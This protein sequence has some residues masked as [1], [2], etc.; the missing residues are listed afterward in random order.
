V[1]DK[2]LGVIAQVE[3]ATEDTLDK[4]DSWYH[5]SL[6]IDKSFVGG[7]A[8]VPWPSGV[9]V[10]EAKGQQQWALFQDD[11]RPKLGGCEGK[12]VRGGTTRSF[13]V[14]THEHTVFVVLNRGP[15]DKETMISVVLLQDAKR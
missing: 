7:V 2:N 14:R 13:V 8:D 1:R 12:T 4:V 6:S 5:K 10:T 3:F 15:E 11:V 9:K